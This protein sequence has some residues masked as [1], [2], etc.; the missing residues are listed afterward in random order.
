MRIVLVIFMC[1]T[2][3]NPRYK[4]APSIR[5]RGELNS[6]NKKVVGSSNCS[7]DIYR[8]RCKRRSPWGSYKVHTVPF[9]ERVVLC[10][11]TSR[12]PSHLTPPRLIPDW[13][14]FT[15]R[16]GRSVKKA[17]LDLSGEGKG[18]GTNGGEESPPE[19]WS[20]GSVVSAAAVEISSK[21]G[22]SLWFYG[23]GYL[24]WLVRTVH[25]CHIGDRIIRL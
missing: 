22:E 24:L 2:R 4:T 10:P 21:D 11:N 25:S 13:Y 23:R 7:Q 3:T 12:Y 16:S 6:W 9:P 1:K 15:S 18:S 14:L 17:R 19:M 20:S 5:G 8:G